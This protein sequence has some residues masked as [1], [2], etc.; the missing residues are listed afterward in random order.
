MTH[1]GYVGDLIG[2]PI[3]P[4]PS[5]PTVLFGFALENTGGAG[6]VAQDHIGLDN[7]QSAMLQHRHFPV[8]V[9]REM[10]GFV[11]LAYFEIDGA[12]TERQPG[13][14]QEQHRL[15][16]RAGRK[17]AEQGQAFHRWDSLWT[18]HIQE[19]GEAETATPLA[20]RTDC[21]ISAWRTGSC[22]GPWPCRT[23]YVRPHASHVSGTRQFS[24]YRAIPARNK[25]EHG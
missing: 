13:Q 9:A 7:G 19:R 1:L 25:S 16:A 15:V 17:T 14:R 8:A 18:L 6:K 3:Q 23:S 24:E 21:G 11:L 4:F 10:L 20:R 12:K 2:L 22:G 5:G